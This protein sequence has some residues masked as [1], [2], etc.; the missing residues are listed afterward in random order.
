MADKP[1]KQPPKKHASIGARRN[2]ARIEAL[3]V[4]IGD[5]AVAT[6]DHGRITR[7]NKAALKILKLKEAE[8]LRRRFVD[9]IVPVHSNGQPVDIA[10]SPLAKVYLS[11]QA[12][13]ER[14]LLRRTGSSPL[15]VHV[16]ASPIMF[17]GEPIGSIV[18][19]RD[20]T[21]ELETEKIKSDFISVASHQLRTPLSAINIYTKL[22]EEQL[23]EDDEQGVQHTYIRT[24]LNSVER[25]NELISTLLNITRIEAG[26]VKVRASTVRIANIVNEML[27]ETKPAISDKKLTLKSSVEDVGMLETDNLLVKEI[28]ANLLSNAIK[29]TPAGGEIS[30]ALTA[31]RSDVIFSVKDTG[32]GIPAKDQ[33]LIFTK[34][35][36]ADN[37][38]AADA[39]GTGLGLYLVKV[40]AEHIDGE[41]WFESVENEGSTFFLSLP[42]RGLGVKSGRIK[43]GA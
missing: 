43:I 35:F 36:R 28:V 18:V 41:V 42:R 1:A 40:I 14:V 22:L 17:E 11:G 29:Y 39:N 32:Y 7:I 31:N 37:A 9:V 16:T 24:I 6:D 8:V 33:R 25:M 12:V 2:R 21:Q 23:G 30:V 15:S 4:S 10:N 27:V 3:F 19:F 5:G 26:G 13:R 38:T 20:L 34:F